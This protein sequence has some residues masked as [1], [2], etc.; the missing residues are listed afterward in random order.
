MARSA[1]YRPIERQFQTRQS[2]HRASLE[3]SSLLAPKLGLFEYQGFGCGNTVITILLLCP[4]TPSTVIKVVALTAPGRS[5]SACTLN[6]NGDTRL[7]GKDLAT[8]GS[9]NE[10]TAMGPPGVKPSTTSNER[11][12]LSQKL[13]SSGN[14]LSKGFEGQ[15][16]RACNTWRYRPC[17][18]PTTAH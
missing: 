17:K 11:I 12:S 6:V 9:E 16:H 2:P 13:A 4:L 10:I 5:G 3:S 18:C 8:L 15:G 14:I 7:T 1:P